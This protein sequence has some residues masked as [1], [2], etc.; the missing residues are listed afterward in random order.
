[1]NYTS[2]QTDSDTSTGAELE[3][4]ADRKRGPSILLLLSGLAALLISAWALAGPFEVSG[5]ANVELRWLIVVIGVVVGLVLVFS[6]GR[7]NKK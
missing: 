7:R 4:S 2:Y 5:L 1:M 3:R 6:P